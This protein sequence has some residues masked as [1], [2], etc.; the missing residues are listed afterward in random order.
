MN[1]FIKNFNDLFSNDD[2][3]V[4]SAVLLK[5]N[6]MFRRFY[7]PYTFNSTFVDGKELFNDLYALIDQ[8]I[9]F[10][11]VDLSNEMFENQQVEKKSIEDM[12]NETYRVC[13]CYESIPNLDNTFY[14]EMD[15]F[16]IDKDTYNQLVA[17]FY[18][19]IN[20]LED[21]E[22]EYNPHDGIDLL[23]YPMY[24]EYRKWLFILPKDKMVDDRFYLPLIKKIWYQ[25]EKF[26][27][28]QIEAI[29]IIAEKLEVEVEGI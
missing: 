23:K 17:N 19:C 28:E 1:P 16:K 2:S 6:W 22:L 13:Y 12:F 7:F 5:K 21:L 29:E 20:K 25:K 10:K 15:F 11:K 24:G 4:Y 8:T 27:D 18:P 26:T 14:A 9:L 3:V